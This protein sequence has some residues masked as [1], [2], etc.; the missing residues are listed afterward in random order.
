MSNAI[1]ILDEM[2][3]DLDQ[4]QQMPELENLLSDYVEGIDFCSVT[5]SPS[6]EV[7]CVTSCGGT[8][9]PS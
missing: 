9:I 5:C 2:G 6:C 1:G 4:L 3:I 7:T 8:V